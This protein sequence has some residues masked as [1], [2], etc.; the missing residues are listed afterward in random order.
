MQT[1]HVKKMDKSKADE[2]LQGL[3]AVS[4]ADSPAMYY[5]ARELFVGYWKNEAKKGIV[6][7]EKALNG[8]E[9]WCSPLLEGWYAGYAPGIPNTNNGNEATN[10]RLKDDI[11]NWELVGILNL[12][13]K[14]AE[15]ISFE[16][17]QRSP[18]AKDQIPVVFDY[19]TEIPRQ[20]YE[21][22]YNRVLQ[23]TQTTEG[24]NRVYLWYNYYHSTDHTKSNPNL[25]YVTMKFAK[26]RTK[27]NA[28]RIIQTYHENNF[29]TFEEYKGFQDNASVLTFSPEWSRWKC[30]CYVFGREFVCLDSIALDHMTHLTKGTREIPLK[31]RTATVVVAKG[32]VGAPVKVDTKHRSR[33]YISMPTFQPGDAAE[34]VEMDDIH[35]ASNNGERNQRQSSTK[36]QGT[37]VPTPVPDLAIFE[38]AKQKIVSRNPQG[39]YD[40]P[41]ANKFNERLWTIVARTFA[42]TEDEVTQLQLFRSHLDDASSIERL[43]VEVLVDRSVLSDAKGKLST[44]YASTRSVDSSATFAWERLPLAW[45]FVEWLELQEAARLSDAEVVQLKLKLSNKSGGSGVSSSAMVAAVVIDD[46]QLPEPTTSPQFL[47]QPGTSPVKVAKQPRKRPPQSTE[48]WCANN[49]DKPSSTAVASSVVPVG[50]GIARPLSKKSSNALSV[51]VGLPSLCISHLITHISN[52]FSFCTAIDFLHRFHMM[53]WWWSGY[54]PYHQRELLSAVTTS[55]MVALSSYDRMLIMSHSG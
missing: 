32:K 36:S 7:V 17:Y 40:L 52:L 24:S 51:P 12:V 48:E 54:C 21:G 43:S 4:A 14:F 22:A 49:F 5:K 27:E 47:P 16:S 50:S 8:F 30:T 1:L 15:W 6:G 39:Y 35:P 31:F 29:S 41:H 25:T 10:L 20:T 13:P 26:D 23:S 38:S 34:P 9:Y 33:Y 45:M 19:P 42:L 53:S 55:R 11:T 2:F 3:N 46:R 37:F 44:Y 18:G 28:K